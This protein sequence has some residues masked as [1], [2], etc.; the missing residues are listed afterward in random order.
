[1]DVI[2]A[3]LICLDIIPHFPGPA[4][5]VPGR[6]TEVGAVELA[7]GG[8]VA[9]TGLALHRL[10]ISTG[11]MGKVGN[12]LF[13]G[14]IL[15]MIRCYD[16]ALTDGMAV[17]PG[18]TSSYSVVISPPNMDRIF[19]HCPGA[20]HSFGAQDVRYDLAAQARLFHLGYPPF[21]RR[22]Y[23]QNGAELAAIFRQ[24]KAL[25]AT[26]SLDM[27]LPDP[28]GPSGQVDWQALLALTLPHVDLFLP[29]AEE[30]CFM[31]DRPRYD[32][33]QSESGPQNGLLSVAEIQGLAQRCLEMGTRAVMIKCG[34]RGLYART[35]PAVAQIGKASPTDPANWMEREAWSPC[36]QPD[37]LA[38]T[39]GSGDA[40][41]AGFLAALLRGQSFETA[42][43]MACAVGACNVEAPDALGGLRSWE[44]TTLRIDSGWPRA[45]FNLPQDGWR[46]AAN[47]LWYG[48][49]DRPGSPPT[50]G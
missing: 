6:L 20:N 41:I 8:A 47:G 34:E 39:T 43:T 22:L 40:T 4:A 21:M 11:L 23:D 38:G 9:N 46:Q 30:L 1:M 7:T 15:D 48:P 44:D 13:G 35:G 18:E 25:G 17:V 10:G 36:F 50:G 37:L 5:L 32:R 19:F 45:A 2:V 12:D 16:P 29:S 31:L 42:I 33:L 49:H 24:V 3:G 26:T 14:A 27:A 28:A